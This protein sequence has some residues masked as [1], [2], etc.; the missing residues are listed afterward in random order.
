MKKTTPFR[1]HANR[2]PTQQLNRGGNSKAQVYKSDFPETSGL[3]C[4]F[5]WINAHTLR[6]H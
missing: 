2:T 4:C 6:K 1:I 5:T 3:L